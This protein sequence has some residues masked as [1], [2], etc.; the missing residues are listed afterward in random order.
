MVTLIPIEPLS[1][2]HGM[3]I[4]EAFSKLFING[5]G[6]PDGF[7]EGWGY[8]TGDGDGCSYDYGDDDYDW[9]GNNPIEEW[10]VGP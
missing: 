8:G 9:G 6:Q 10:H 4:V 1:G 7:G 2:A 5:G 3:L